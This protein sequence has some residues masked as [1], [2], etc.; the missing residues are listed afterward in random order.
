MNDLAIVTL[1]PRGQQLGQRI[2]QA[3]GCG[4]I[5]PAEDAVRSRLTELFRAG[6]PLVCVMAL[7]IVVRILGPLTASKQTDPPVVVVDE[8]GRFAVSVLGGHQAGAND[9]AEAVGRAIGALPV[10]TTASEA[11][12]LPPLDLLGKPWGWQREDDAD[13]TALA[14]AAVRGQPIAVYQDAGCPFWW[15]AYP[16][17]PAHFHW[18]PT[19]P[20]GSWAGVLAITDRLWPRRDCPMVIYRPKTLILGVGC[21]RGV[22]D[23]ELEEL[24]Q[25]V[26]QTHRLAPRSLAAVATVTLKENEPGLRTFAQRHGVPLQAY[27]VAA[28]AAVGHL[29]TPSTQV[30]RLIGISG[31]AEPA[32]LLAASTTT[33]L[34]PKC[35]GKRATMAVAR[36]KED[37]ER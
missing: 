26:W 25:Q 6:R 36:R 20:E 11:L 2:V 17:W 32:A 24:F 8:A 31:V 9:L 1:T 34:V 23:S 5:V 28:L 21:R 27:P 3:L 15:Q 16:R 29:A 12:Q 13:L 10:V 37:T 33:L 4:A 30:R 22:P 18:V 19:W 35:K 7:G 14:A